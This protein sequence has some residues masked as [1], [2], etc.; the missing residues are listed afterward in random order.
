MTKK[1]IT[2]ILLLHSIRGL[3]FSQT[4]ESYNR[5]LFHSLPKNFPDSI[6]C[7]DKLGKKQAWWIFYKV[8]YNPIDR[9][10]ELAVGDYV[11]DYTY[12][13][14]KDDQKIGT[15][16]TIFNVH[17]I[18]TIRQDT[19]Y[20]SNDTSR[21]TS[22]FGGGFEKSDIL[23]TKDSNIIKSTSLAPKDEFPICLDCYKKSKMCIMTYRREVI[24]VFPFEDFDY[25]F[26][27]S[28]DRYENDKILI[29]E[30]HK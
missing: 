23:Y 4:C 30:K 3:T 21:V 22:W 20:Y 1:I 27:R 18:R 16:E 12:G 14:Y 17:L 29:N 13:E 7:I 19:Y 11:H 6:N 26:K 25:E 15:W 2:L 10:D 8:Q 5:K 24:K 9:P 28:F